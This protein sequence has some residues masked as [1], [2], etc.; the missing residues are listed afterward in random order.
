MYIIFAFYSEAKAA[1]HF[2]DDRFTLT[3]PMPLGGK[4]TEELNFP[5]ALTTP[6]LSLPQFGL[7]VHSMQIPIPELFVPETITVFVP[8]F[9]KAEVSTKVNSNLYDLEASASAGRDAVETP[10]YS[11]KIEVAGNSPVDILSIKIEGTIS[12]FFVPNCMR[13]EGNFLQ[14]FLKSV[15]T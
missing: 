4:S 3:L 1:Y 10:S 11:A 7:E 14:C 12:I 15:Y 5:P 6:R 2:N 13:A 9:G 8:L